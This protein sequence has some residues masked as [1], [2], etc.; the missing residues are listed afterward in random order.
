MLT[1]LGKCECTACVTFMCRTTKICRSKWSCVGTANAAAP[2]DQIV[3]STSK[4]R[5]QICSISFFCLLV[6]LHWFFLIL[7]IFILVGWKLQIFQIFKFKIPI[8]KNKKRTKLEIIRSKNCWKQK[9]YSRLNLLRQDNWPKK[10]W[11][12][13]LEYSLLCVCVCLRVYVFTVLPLVDVH[14]L[15]GFHMRAQSKDTHRN[16][17]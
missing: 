14:I 4:N 17:S 1:I 2:P 5:T 15:F 8:K 16:K 3:T 6:T 13:R 9:R 10:I 12:F 11:F 7:L